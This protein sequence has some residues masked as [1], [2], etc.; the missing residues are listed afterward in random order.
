MLSADSHASPTCRSFLDTFPPEI[1]NKIYKHL[2]CSPLLADAAAEIDDGEGNEDE[3]DDENKIS[4]AAYPVQ[5][6]LFP[7]ILRT[8]RQ[9][10]EEASVILYEHN[11]FYF[12]CRGPWEWS[13]YH[14]CVGIVPLC[15][16]TRRCPILVDACQLNMEDGM[17][18]FEDVPAASK[19]RHWKV[20]VDACGVEGKLVKLSVNLHPAFKTPSLGY[21]S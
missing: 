5:Y 1:R 12:V 13:M 4:P 3:N 6:N 15:P 18:G 21:Q 14:S 8:C 9:I 16:L 11:T 7:A 20:Y 19:V 10:Y 2:L 17:A